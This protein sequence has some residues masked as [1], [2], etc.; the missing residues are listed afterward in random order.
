MRDEDIDREKTTQEINVPP[1]LTSFSNFGLM[2]VK[3]PEGFK[4]VSSKGEVCPRFDHAAAGIGVWVNFRRIEDRRDQV[5][6]KPRFWVYVSKDENGAPVDEKPGKIVLETD[7]WQEV[8][9]H[10]QPLI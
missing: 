5:K 3:F 6:D 7:D 8:L 10:C 2:D 1:Y 9:N 4:D